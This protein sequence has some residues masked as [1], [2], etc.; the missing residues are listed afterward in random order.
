MHVYLIN[1]MQTVGDISSYGL[2]PVFPSLY[3][4]NTM[5]VYNGGYTNYQIWL[6]TVYPIK[7]LDLNFKIC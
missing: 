1:N 7:I 4:Y 5:I 3:W 2:K 6:R